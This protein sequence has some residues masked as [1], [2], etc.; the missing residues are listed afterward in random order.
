MR[1]HAQPNLRADL[2]AYISSCHTHSGSLVNWLSTEDVQRLHQVRQPVSFLTRL[3]VSIFILLCTLT[4]AAARHSHL[5]RSCIPGPRQASRWP[6]ESAAPAYPVVPGMGRFFRS[7]HPV[8]PASASPPLLRDF[9]RGLGRDSRSGSCSGTRDP[10]PICGPTP[11]CRC[12]PAVQPPPPQWPWGSPGDILQGFSLRPS[13][14][15]FHCSPLGAAERSV[16]SVCLGLDLSLPR[17]L[18]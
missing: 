7:D 11:Y 8:P 1:A 5:N 2:P 16:S 9:L 10:S 17:S 6:R 3:Q 4:G 14:R 15:L 12:A 18:S 13:F